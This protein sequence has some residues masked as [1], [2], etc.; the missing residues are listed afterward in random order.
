MSQRMILVLFVAAM[1]LL[2]LATA[3][4]VTMGY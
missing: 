3:G 4:I 2:V 1:A